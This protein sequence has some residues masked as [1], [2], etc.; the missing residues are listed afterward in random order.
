MTKRNTQVLVDGFTF[1]EGPRWRNG[2]LW[3]AEIG[4]G[5]VVIVTPEGGRR[6]V[7]HV[8]GIPSGL[9]FL[10]NGTPIVVSIRE[11]R[12][13]RIN[14]STLEEHADLSTLSPFL[15]DMV[16]DRQ[17]RAYVGNFGFDVLQGEPMKP[18]SIILVQPDGQATVVARG[19]K[20]PNG[21]VVTADGRLIVAESFA[22]RLTSF[23]INPDGT[24]GE[25][26]TQAVLEGAPDG[27]CLD[28]EGGIWVALFDKSRFVRVLNGKVVET[29]ETPGRHAIACQ[30]GGTDGRTLFCLTYAGALED[31]GKALTAQVEI[32]VVDAVGAGS[33]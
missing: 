7:V 19:L 15:N 21:S 1:L 8:P 22:N 33:P 23:P 13:M 2:E 4:A 14:G 30:L 29:I 18:G 10:P 20:G 27:I 16:V 25:Q 9:G 3:M 6:T 28:I 24:L 12:L 32:V 11:R 5:D 17:G 31:V 26:S